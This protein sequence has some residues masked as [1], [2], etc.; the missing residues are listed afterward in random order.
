MLLRR[1]YFSLSETV[2]WDDE[3]ETVTKRLTTKNQPMPPH[4]RILNSNYLR[5]VWQHTNLKTQAMA[6]RT[7]SLYLAC[8][9]PLEQSDTL[10]L[11]G[12]ALPHL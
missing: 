3:K 1:K 11:P 10:S 9:L 4:T 8:L 12:I 7:S 5:I 6:Y 2:I